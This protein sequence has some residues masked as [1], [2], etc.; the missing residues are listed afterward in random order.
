MNQ[1]PV[2]LAVVPSSDD[3][4]RIVVQL[5]HGFSGSSVELLQQS[6]GEGVGWFT[7]SKVQLEPEQLTAV[8]A[9]L[10]SQSSSAAMRRCTPAATASSMRVVHAESA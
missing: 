10:G 4:H 7:Q 1:N 3:Q 9:A 6:W 2:T 8:R 5:R